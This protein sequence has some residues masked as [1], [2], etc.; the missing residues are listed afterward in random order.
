MMAFVREDADALVSVFKGLAGRAVVASSSDVY[1]PMGSL[2]GPSPVRRSWRRST[3]TGRCGQRPSIH[4]S[5]SEKKDVEQ[6]VLG[7]PDLPT[8]VL[9]Y[10]AIYGPGSYR[11]QDWFKRMLDNRPAI[12]LGKG[13]ATFR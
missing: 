12:I 5:R 13:W 8:C 7:E 4:G 11:R 10:P 3:R 9:R 1:R 2:T 6:V